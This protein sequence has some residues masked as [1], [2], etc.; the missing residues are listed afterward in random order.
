MSK[1]TAFQPN[2]WDSFNKHVNQTSDDNNFCFENQ[3]NKE[4]NNFNIESKS[5]NSDNFGFKQNNANSLS[6]DSFGSNQP[7][8]N[9]T[10]QDQQQDY[11]Q[12]FTSAPKKNHISSK[13]AD[14]FNVKEDEKKTK[15]F[16]GSGN[17]DLLNFNE[18]GKKTEPIKNFNIMEDLLGMEEKPFEKKEEINLY[19]LNSIQF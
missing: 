13:K 10:Y 1:N 6:W 7:N 8:L 4:L 11:S 16:L 17:D 19:D 15:N 3:S 14:L 18:T 5:K 12:F 9:G 2:Y